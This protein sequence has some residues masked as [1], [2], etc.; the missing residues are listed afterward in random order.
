MLNNVC[1]IQNGYK[2][3]YICIGLRLFRLFRSISCP[4]NFGSILLIPWHEVYHSAV[5]LLPAVSAPE[6][7]GELA[8]PAEVVSLQSPPRVPA[9]SRLPRPPDPDPPPRA[10]PRHLAHAAQGVRVPARPHR[11]HPHALGLGQDSLEIAAV[12]T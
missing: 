2:Y 8:P 6:L 7:E 1:T 9:H 10:T 3:K 5:A 4:L 12:E 11:P